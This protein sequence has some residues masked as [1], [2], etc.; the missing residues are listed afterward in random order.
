MSQKRILIIKTRILVFT[1]RKA[2]FSIKTITAHPGATLT[3]DLDV[4]VIMPINQIEQK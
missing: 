2:M 4:K 1:Q 3:T